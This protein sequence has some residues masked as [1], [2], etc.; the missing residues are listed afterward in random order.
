LR[1]TFSAQIRRARSSHTAVLPQSFG[2]STQPQRVCEPCLELLQESVQDTSQSEPPAFQSL[3]VLKAGPLIKKGG[4]LKSNASK[5]RHFVVT[6][7]GFLHYFDS[8]F[9][10][11]PKGSICLHYARIIN[12]DSDACAFN[13]D[14]EEAGGPQGGFFAL[15]QK[16]SKTKFILRTNLGSM[17]RDVW[18]KT[19]QGCSNYG[20]SVA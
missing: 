17:E 13:I 6:R 19:L 18:V 14:I 3:E 8:K 7:A 12:D 5:Q 9:D 1:P 11:Q 15:R 16:M 4:M 10:P 2:F 20:S